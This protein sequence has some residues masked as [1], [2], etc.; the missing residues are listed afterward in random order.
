MDWE[1][2]KQE[3]K[4]IRQASNL[5]NVNF[6]FKDVICLCPATQ[7]LLVTIDRK[8]VAHNFLVNNPTFRTF[9]LDDAL[10]GRKVLIIVTNKVVP[11]L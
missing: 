8:S 1:G 11:V 2:K 10:F 9:S 5:L 3:E 4:V 7:S 6:C